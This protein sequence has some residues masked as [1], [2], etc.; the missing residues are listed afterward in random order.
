MEHKQFD[1]VH[2]LQFMIEIKGKDCFYYQLFGLNKRSV[3]PTP[4]L[5]QFFCLEQKIF[6]LC[7][8]TNLNLIQPW[9][10]KMLIFLAVS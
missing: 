3:F 1:S 4:F 7:P 6:Y 8:V 10:K 9:N 2:T 5:Y